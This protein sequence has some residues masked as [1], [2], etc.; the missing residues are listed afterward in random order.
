[1]SLRE[2]PL[3]VAAAEARS[4]APSRI[5]VFAAQVPTDTDRFARALGLPG[6][7]KLFNNQPPASFIFGGS[8]VHTDVLDAPFADCVNAVPS[9]PRLF[10]WHKWPDEPLIHLHDSKD[11]GPD[12]VAAQTKDQIASDD[13][14]RFVDRRS[15]TC[16]EASRTESPFASIRWRATHN[17]PQSAGRDL[18]KGS[19]SPLSA[20]ESGPCF[21][22]AARV[23]P[24]T[25]PA[26]R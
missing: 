2:L 13:F 4:I 16:D 1:M 9:K 8:D 17:A 5:D 14:W 6:R 7:S 26:V 25:A 19:R 20:T 18:R 21:G 12:I 15:R 22:S 10:L 3:I 23:Q 11:D 24:A